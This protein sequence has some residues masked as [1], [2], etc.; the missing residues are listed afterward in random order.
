MKSSR[1]Q[2]VNNTMYRYAY[3]E[4]LMHLGVPVTQVTSAL[5]VDSVRL[6]EVNRNQQLIDIMKKTFRK[7]PYETMALRELS[8]ESSC[9][10]LGGSIVTD[11]TII[12]AAGQEIGAVYDFSAKSEIDGGSIYNQD[13]EAGTGEFP[14]SL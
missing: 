6:S 7:K 4:Y 5:G 2:S 11:E 12:E 10:L 9:S 1:K 14:S 3:A 8:L 13:W